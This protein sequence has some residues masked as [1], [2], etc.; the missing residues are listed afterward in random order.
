MTSPAS[1]ANTITPLM[2]MGCTNVTLTY[3]TAGY[4]TICLESASHGV[5]QLAGFNPSKGDVIGIDDIVEQTTAST[6]LS[7]ISKYITSSISSVGTTLYFDP[8]GKGLQGTPFAVL[9]GVD[10]TVAQLVADGGM[11]YVPDAIT[12]TPQFN[13]P[14]NMR[15]A[16]LETVDLLHYA[17]GIG[18]Q[19]INGFNPNAGDVLELRANSQPDGCRPRSLQYLQLRQRRHRQRKHHSL[20]RRHR[21]RSPQRGL[22]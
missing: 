11:K 1:T 3:R 5:Q 9:Q 8:T 2:R 17:P 12:V 18:P 16:G 14:L 6:N 21:L 4:E 22:R 7:D 10:T 15:A 19:Q 20:R 13:T